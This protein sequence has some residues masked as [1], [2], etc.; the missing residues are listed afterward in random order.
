MEQSAR[1]CHRPLCMLAHDLVNKLS[2]IIGCCDLL[3]DSDR[4]DPEDAKHVQRIRD[5]AKSMAERLSHEQCHLVSV[6]Q[7]MALRKETSTH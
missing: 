4:P 3:N 7:S 5:T 6:A 1:E 2:V